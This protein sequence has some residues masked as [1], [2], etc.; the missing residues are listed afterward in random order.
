MKRSKKRVSKKKEAKIKSKSRYGSRSKIKRVKSKKIK[1]VKGGSGKA[2]EDQECNFISET[3]RGGLNSKCKSFFKI[4]KPDSDGTE[5]S[6]YL[7]FDFDLDISD[8][9]S[10]VVG[11]FGF[12]LGAEYKK[13]KVNDDIKKKTVSLDSKYIDPFYINLYYTDSL[14]NLVKEKTKDLNESELETFKDKWNSIPRMA[15]IT[16][17]EDSDKDKILTFEAKEKV[18]TKPAKGE[19]IYGWKDTDNI[20][21]YGPTLMNR[22][23]KFCKIKQES[24]GPQITTTNIPGIPSKG[25]MPAGISEIEF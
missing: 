2:I 4:K 19:S 9:Y 23:M 20:N 24:K 11:V 8:V 18:K 7:R 12:E 1:S 22:L 14:K 17:D 15:K 13:V 21:L 6:D 3:V 10:G 16:E 25:P 5:N